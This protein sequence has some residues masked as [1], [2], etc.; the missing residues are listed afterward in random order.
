MKWTVKK[1]EPIVD[2]LTKAEHKRLNLILQIQEMYQTGI[3]ICEIAR[4]F[5]VARQTIRKYIN[6]D[7]D[8]LCRSNKRSSLD[9]HKDYI[10]TCLSEG[11][12]QAETARCVMEL[13]VD[14]CL[15][16]IKQYISSV[17]KEYQI[18]VNKYVSGTGE[19][20]KSQKKK[21]EYVTRKGIF[22]YLWM[23]GNLTP[24]HHE[25]LWEKYDVLAELEKCIREFRENFEKQNLS[26][27][28]LFIERYQNSSIK[29]L[30]SFS[31][32]LNGDICAVEN[33]VASDLSNGFVEGTNSKIKM[34][35]RTMY[36]RCGKKLLEAK[37]MY[38]RE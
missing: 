2:N 19:K 32:G 37:L 3:G 22:Q 12:T 14:T 20:N 35:K 15:G 1:I 5:K 21:M 11:K 33:A 31:K 4:R 28:Y 18:E 27:L 36:G 16:N 38:N 30:A 17:R 34:I 24:A 6:G 25:F 23:N 9:Q 13:G 7:P 26:L 8:I 29:E 10:I